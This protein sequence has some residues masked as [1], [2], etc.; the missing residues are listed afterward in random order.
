MADL[1]Q[2]KP[3][4]WKHIGLYGHAV[5]TFTSE[6]ILLFVVHPALMCCC[7]RWLE[8]VKSTPVALADAQ[9]ALYELIF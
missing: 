5:G 7:D 8:K 9:N 4:A 3:V 2:K 1:D 6:F